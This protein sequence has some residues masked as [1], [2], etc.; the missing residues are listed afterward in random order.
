M[1]HRITYVAAAT[2]LALSASASLPTAIGKPLAAP[3][4]GD[5]QIPRPTSAF[6]YQ[7]GEDRRYLLG[8]DDA[9]DPGEWAEWSMRLERLQEGDDGWEAHFSMAHDRMERLPDSLDPT[10]LITVNVYGNLVVNLDGFPLRLDYVQEF[11][12]RGETIS[13]DGVRRIEYQFDRRRKRF[14]KVVRVGK[15]DWDFNFGVAKYSHM[16][17]EAPRGLY[18]FMPTALDCLGA[19]RSACND[20]DPAFGNPGLLSLVMP[21]LLEESGGQRNF[22]FM[23]P[24]AIAVSPFYTMERSGD[25]VS[26][27]RDSI[28]NIAR[29]FDERKLELGVSTEVEVGPRT[30]HGWELDMGGGVDKVWVEPEGRVLRIDL[31]T[32]YDIRKTRFIRLVFPSE[33]FGTNE[34]PARECC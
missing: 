11:S 23:L 15:R 24:S 33:R 16:D 28:G 27:E 26:Y 8:P 17:L 22:M 9:L 1:N 13:G 34:D 3:Q 7:I 21:A 19:S 20:V 10:D 6:G 12:L 30:M 29:Y 14:E 31:D 2:V 32:T 5:R 4:E 25:W 18:V